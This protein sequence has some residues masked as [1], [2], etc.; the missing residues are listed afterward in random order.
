VKAIKQK[1]VLTVK[2]EIMLEAEAV[3]V[4]I[5]AVIKQK[6]KRNK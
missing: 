2:R 6:I 5:I 1:V 3:A 4:I